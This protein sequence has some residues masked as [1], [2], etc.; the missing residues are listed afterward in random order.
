MHYSS[1]VTAQN[2]HKYLV[3]IPT[4]V[5]IIKIPSVLSEALIVDEIEYQCIL[6]DL[7]DSAEALYLHYVARSFEVE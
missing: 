7:L 3:H 2:A 1:L 6:V 5:V 4:N